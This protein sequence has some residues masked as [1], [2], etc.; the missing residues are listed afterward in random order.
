MKPVPWSKCLLLLPQNR[1]DCWFEQCLSTTHLHDWV[2]ESTAV[3][4]RVC[5]CERDKSWFWQKGIQRCCRTCGTKNSSTRRSLCW[6]QKDLMSIEQRLPS[7]LGMN[8]QCRHNDLTIKK[9]IQ[10]KS[11]PNA[12]VNNR[13]TEDRFPTQAAVAFQQH[14]G[15][16]PSSL[17]FY[18][19]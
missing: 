4:Y 16:W 11:N 15:N 2:A 5:P 12:S 9:W 17:S 3:L 10:N 6:L 14:V 19:N 8:S 1:L 13:P 18:N 7:F